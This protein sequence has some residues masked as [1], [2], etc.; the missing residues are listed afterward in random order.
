MSIGFTNSADD[1][2]AHELLG[3]RCAEA[4]RGLEH[5]AARGGFQLGGRDQLVDEAEAQ[6]LVRAHGPAGEHQIHRGP[7]A[8]QAHASAP[9]R[10][11]PG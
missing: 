1:G 7:H 9:C 8:D 11:I 10:R 3:D 5:E 2:P 4:G 6:R